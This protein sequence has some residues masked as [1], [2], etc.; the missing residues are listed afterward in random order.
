MPWWSWVLIWAGL[1]LAMLGMFA[2][3]GWRLFR[4][5]VGAMDELGRL[6][7]KTEM[8]GA[9]ADE[10]GEPVR[11]PAILRDGA[12]VRAEHRRLADERANRVQVRRDNRLA[13]GRLL[14]RADYRINAF[15]RKGA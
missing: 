7:A 5:A 3:F 10:L 11:I 13:R 14:V 6:M 12:E 2:F 8:L 9:L 4:K 15:Q 1:V